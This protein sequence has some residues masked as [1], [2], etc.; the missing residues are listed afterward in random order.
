MRTVVRKHGWRKDSVDHYR[1]DWFSGNRKEAIAQWE[2][3]PL[4][5]GSLLWPRYYSE[6]RRDGAGWFRFENCA[7]LVFEYLLDGS[8]TYTQNGVTETVRPGEIYVM[9]PGGD[10]VFHAETG[11]CFHRHRLMICGT[12]AQELDLELHL[13]GCN[14]F[15]LADSGPFIGRLCG[16][17]ERMA[18]HRPEEAA[19]LSA[20]VYSL[21]TGFASEHSR[22]RV[23]TVPEPLKRV[24]QEMRKDPAG[25]RTVREIAEAHG[26]EVHMLMRLFHRHLGVSPLEYRNRLRLEN[27]GRLAAH[28]ELSMKEIAEQLGYRSPLYFSTAFRREFGVSPSEYRRRNRGKME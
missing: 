12:L 26:M 27:A 17:A 2:N 8:L 3:G 7:D 13:Y 11:D 16:I 4:P 9:H 1:E 25:G 15:Q 23:E 10:I 5:Y 21:I 20:M 14:V 6:I 18:A 19:E 28:S 22:S 24:L